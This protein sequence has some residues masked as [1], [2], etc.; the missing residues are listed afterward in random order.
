MAIQ[1]NPTE[2]DNVLNAI[3]FRLSRGVGRVKKD[4][5][6]SFFTFNVEFLPATLNTFTTQ[7]FLVQNDSA[8]VV[9]RTSYVATLTDNITPV[10]AVTVPAPATTL[11]TYGIAAPF[12]V[13]IVDSGSG[14]QFSNIDSHIDNW[15]GDAQQ[16]FFW[17]SPQVLDPN[18]NVTVRIQN[19]STTVSYNVRCAFIGY[20]VFGDVA[21]FKSIKGV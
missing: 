12:L 7:S 1:A 20:K 14:R 2:L 9:T 4:F 21:A 8:F 18:S 11:L 15:F 6:L 13:N 19:L 16:P 17:P 3:A 5:N 10:N